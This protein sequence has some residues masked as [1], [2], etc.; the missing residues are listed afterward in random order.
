MLAAAA[1]RA[2]HLRQCARQ[3]RAEA[4][5]RAD[6]LRQLTGRD[7]DRRDGRAERLGHLLN[8]ARTE[9]D[10]EDLTARDHRVSRGA[11]AR[12]DR[13]GER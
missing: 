12:C 5:G 4:R 3:R 9:L 1:D 6:L 13:R 8:L 11:E 10:A 2:A 7:H